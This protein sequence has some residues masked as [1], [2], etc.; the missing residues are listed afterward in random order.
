[1]SRQKTLDRITYLVNIVV[2]LPVFGRLA[3]R[4]NTAILRQN[5]MKE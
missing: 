1:M 5:A 4:N 3:N 2:A